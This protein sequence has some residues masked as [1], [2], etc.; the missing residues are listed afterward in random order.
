MAASRT[1]PPPA[2]PSATA[3]AHFARGVQLHIAGNDT[4]AIRAYRCAIAADPGLPEAW[5]NLGTLLANVNSDEAREHFEKAVALN[6]AYGEALNNLGIFCSQNGDHTAALNAFERAVACDATRPDWL[7]SLANA[8]VEHFRFAEALDAYDR[9]IALDAANADCWSNRA[10]ALRGLRRPDEAI[11]SLRH[12]LTLRPDNVDALS[13]LGIILKEQKL[14][15]DAESS[16]KRA[17]ELAPQNPAI[18]VNYASVFEMQGRYDEMRDL[19]R[20]ALSLDPSYVE[21]HNI[22][23][24]GALE[25]GDI[26][27]AE[28]TLLRVIASDPLNRNANWNLALI[29]LMRG[30]FVQGWKQYEWRKRI[31]S[32]V[33]EH[34][35]YPGEE[36]NGSPLGGRSILLYSEQGIGDAIQFVRYAAVLKEHG[37]GKVHMECPYP[38]APLLS[39]VEGVDGVVARGTEFPDVDLNVSIMSLPG[40]LGT[41]LDTIPARVPYIPLEPR[42]VASLVTA[43][44]GVRKIGIVW[45]GSTAHARDFL[46]SAPLD[47]FGRLFSIPGTKFFSLQKGDAAEAQLHTLPDGLVT[48]LAPHLD[49]FRDTAAAIQALDLVITVDTSVAHLAGALGRPTWLLLPS[50]PD[51]RWMLDREDSPWYP[52]MRLFRQPQARDWESVFTNVETA[53][54][55]GEIVSPTLAPPTPSGDDIVTLATAARVRDGRSRF[56]LWFPL[57]RLADGDDFRAYQ[58]E[59]LG[60]LHEE[61]IRLFLD[62][63]LHGND[64]FI[65]LE[66]GLGLTMLS[67]ASAPTAPAAL[68]L[69]P[70]D[71][72]DETRL[73]QLVARRAPSIDLSQHTDVR[74]AL[75]VWQRTPKPRRIVVRTGYKTDAAEIVDAIGR[76]RGGDRPDAVLWPDAAAEG[77]GGATKFLASLGYLHVALGVDEGGLTVN[78]LPDSLTGVTVVS[79]TDDFFASLSAVDASASDGAAAHDAPT[80]AE[81]PNARPTTIT[82]TAYEAPK[83]ERASTRAAIGIDW[84]LR[85][86]SGWGVYGTNLVAQLAR[87]A[88]IAPAIFVADLRE[89]PPVTRRAIEPVVQQAAVRADE[90]N[91]APNK[92]FDFDG[93]ML[94][95]LSNNIVP[96][97]L[98]QR[99]RARRNAGVIFFEDTAFDADAIARA[100][101]FDLIIT[102]ST[103]NEEVLRSRGVENVATVLQGIDPTI[104]HPAP[105]S[106][107]LSSRFVVFSGGKLEYRKGQ[108]IVAAAFRAFQQKHRDA[109]LVVAWHNA[110]PQL[111]SD[112]DRRGHVR[113]IPRLSEGELQLPEWLADNGIPRDAVL[114]IG[115]LP[116]AMMGQV[117]READVALF[118]N[119]CEGGTN[120][121]AMECMA[122]GVP[123]IVSNNT[124]HRDLVATG[125]CIPLEVQGSVTPPS[126]FFRGIEGWGESSI[127]EIV[128][129]LER[130]YNDRQ[131]ASHIAARGTQALGAMS[132]EAQTTRFIDA[133]RPLLA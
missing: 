11:F 73:A 88:D 106:G 41:T 116:N 3:A 128:A 95:A 64:C 101:D 10:L 48:D 2:P 16:L 112:L 19:A 76:T 125:G 122:S 102:G 85:S 132:W 60:T 17:T 87:R 5:N 99:L 57:A 1:Q 78:A 50:V 81:A 13:N 67:V 53:L 55:A 42:P 12:S 15:A 121:V 119:R 59:L 31:Q 6:P 49:D 34:F 26:D 75:A 108:D 72:L 66:P 105:R 86:D 103:W 58:S 29:W 124:G 51:F 39:G 8:L 56:D 54:E 28:E 38:I 46:R 96:G 97:P 91:R 100:R 43:P 80:L 24:N 70:R 111:I 71:H 84:E 32:V 23:A 133:V 89:M 63:V 69:V 115:R 40:L 113:G 120:L 77:V 98:W 83:L 36:W 123:T 107:L 94:R 21:A 14:F 131:S 110:W 20:H 25:S 61:G 93:L 126:Q 4:E 52:T 30:D 104:F 62:E 74:S 90:M 37:A 27:R 9:A 82:T 33:V 117:V 7:N 22:L 47:A 35:A 79:I 129:Q 109:L 92:V 118:P 130:L 68:R 65:D 18:W 44:E 127:D 114:D 45:A